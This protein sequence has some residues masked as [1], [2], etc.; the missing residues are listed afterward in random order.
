MQN[1]GDVSDPFQSNIGWHIMRLE[2]KIPVPPYEEVEGSLK[3]RVAPDERMK[4]S[5]QA[6][7]IKRKKDL[8][9]VENSENKAKVM[10]LADSDLLK[11]KWKF[12]GN[13]QL[14]KLILRSINGK[15]LQA[16]DFFDWIAQQ[17][18]S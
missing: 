12:V 16:G 5:E 7:A 1:P 13:P 9:F 18:R 4:I 6:A 10:A 8:R 14:K 15:D 11:G 2:K 3:K 17:H